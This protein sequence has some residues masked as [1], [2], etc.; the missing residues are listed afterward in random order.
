MTI[1][2]KSANA[3]NAAN[4]TQDRVSKLEFTSHTIGGRLLCVVTNFGVVCDMGLIAATSDL[5]YL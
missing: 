5:L 2:V 3:C 1:S 4:M